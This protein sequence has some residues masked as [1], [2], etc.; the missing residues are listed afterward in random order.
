MR[1]IN[2]EERHRDGSIEAMGY[3]EVLRAAT[4]DQSGVR[5]GVIRNYISTHGGLLAQLA[6]GGFSGAGQA[7][8]GGFDGFRQHRSAEQGQPGFTHFADSN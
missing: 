3:L 8:T 5:V 2:H 4:S 7:R 1:F 6:R